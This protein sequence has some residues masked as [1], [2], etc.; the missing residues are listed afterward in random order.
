[1][2]FMSS[3]LSVSCMNEW[4]WTSEWFG[5]GA[6]ADDVLWNGMF[7]F[8]ASQPIHLLRVV[9]NTSFSE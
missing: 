3:I 1:M 7:V 9:Q 8:K 2:F 4:K 6:D 5:G